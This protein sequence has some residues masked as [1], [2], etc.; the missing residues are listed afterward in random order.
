[1][2]KYSNRQR[3]SDLMGKKKKTNKSL[4]RERFWYRNGLRI[5]WMRKRA[6]LPAVTPHRAAAWMSVDCGRS[7]GFRNLKR[8]DPPPDATAAIASSQ[9]F[10]KIET[11]NTM[12]ELPLLRSWHNLV[13]SSPLP[14]PNKSLYRLSIYGRTTLL[15]PILRYHDASAIWLAEWYADRPTD[16]VGSGCGP[17]NGLFLRSAHEGPLRLVILSLKER[18]VRMVHN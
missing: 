18:E 2:I 14:T 4:R 13:R 7:R 3:G 12:Q 10:R 6:A 16:F 9:R 15:W 5:T 11:L 1:M 8:P 17:N